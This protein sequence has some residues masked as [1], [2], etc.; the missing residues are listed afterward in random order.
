MH[1]R[2]Q[3]MKCKTSNQLNGFEQI[4]SDIF[5]RSF[6]GE[7]TLF[8]LGNALGGLEREIEIKQ[9]HQES[10]KL[11]QTLNFIVRLSEFVIP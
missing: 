8:G 1:I 5:W 7:N 6:R 4:F 2:L 11:T 9:L 10:S 3:D